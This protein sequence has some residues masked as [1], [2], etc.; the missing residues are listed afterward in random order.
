MKKTFTFLIVIVGAFII[1]N[2]I[3]TKPREDIQNAEV[4]SE[5][6]LGENIGS[7]TARVSE[8][9]IKNFLETKVSFKG[10]GPG[11][12][13]S[14]SF[15]SVDSTMMLDEN[16][17]PSGRVV[18][19]MDSLLVD[20]EAV[21]K[22][23]KTVDF[24]DVVKFETSIFTIENITNGKADGSMTIHGVTKKISFDVTESNEDFNATFNIDMKDFGINQTFANEVVELSVSIKK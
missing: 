4:S 13:H 14:G 18:V 3:Q 8:E 11:K 20:T 23:L 10:F 1:W 22:H 17:M 15:T 2:L 19:F 5:V 9:G 21:T 24:F 6:I 7:D 12:E 16:G